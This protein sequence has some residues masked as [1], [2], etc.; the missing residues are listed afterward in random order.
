MAALTKDRGT[1]KRKG[2]QLNDPVAASVKIFNG[3]IVVL[4]A[5][6]NAAP[7]TTA[8]A[9][10]ARGISQQ[11]VDNSSGLAGD[12]SVE[13]ERGPHRVANDGSIDRTHIGGTAYLVDDNVVAATDGGGTRSAAG[14]ILDV[15]AK[16]V[17]VDF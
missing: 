13:T 2:K 16:G 14:P 4:D 6:G 3:A 10:V 1:P 12:E 11:Q 15:D 5:A 8:L 17:W 7:A 9:L